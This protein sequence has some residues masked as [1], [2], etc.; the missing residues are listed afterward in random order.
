MAEAPDWLRPG[1]LKMKPVAPVAVSVKLVWAQ[2][3]VLL[4]PGVSVAVGVVLTVTVTLL[5][6]TQPP[7]VAV[8]DT[9]VVLAGV[10]TTLVEL[11]PVLHANESPPE[12]VSVRLLPEQTSSEGVAAML[13]EGGA[14]RVT[15][16]V[17]AVQPFTVVTNTE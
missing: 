2:V 10:N 8:T 1:P 15:L 4:G 7:D 5:T 12:A 6:E 3:S 13:A 16:F 11:L 9:T 14:V 17:M